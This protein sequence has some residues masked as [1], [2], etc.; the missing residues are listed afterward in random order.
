MIMVDSFTVVHIAVLTV[1]ILCMALSFKKE[2][3]D[4]LSQKNSK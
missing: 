2:A 3:K 1:S 4:P